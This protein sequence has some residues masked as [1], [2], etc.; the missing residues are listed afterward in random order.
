MAWIVNVPPSA[1]ARTSAASRFQ[2]G[3]GSAQPVPYGCLHREARVELH[4]A[5]GGLGGVQRRLGKVEPDRLDDG[6]HGQVEHERGGVK[7]VLSEG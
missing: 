6:L 7:V 3:S 2:E 4:A 5:P 1:A